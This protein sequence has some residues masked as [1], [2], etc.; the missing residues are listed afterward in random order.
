MLTCP[1]RYGASGIAAVADPARLDRPTQVLEITVVAGSAPNCPDAPPTATSSRARP[2]CSARW[3]SPPGTAGAC[4][5]RH[6]HQE[7]LAFLEQ[8]ANAFPR[9]Q[10]HQV[11][12]NYATHTHPT[13]RKWL[14]EHP[15]I[16]LRPH[17]VRSWESI[18]P[19]LRGPFR[20][21]TSRAPSF[22]VPAT[23]PGGLRTERPPA[24]LVS[25]LT[26]E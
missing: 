10:Q 24:L 11:L 18:R 19:L 23:S 16:K 4:M 25:G 26:G 3:R 21:H 12:D 22:A 5:P 2:P 14:A 1:N 15:R 17:A 9:R 8:A 20:R 6:R 13:V 7:F